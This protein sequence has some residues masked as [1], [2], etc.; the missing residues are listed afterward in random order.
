MARMAEQWSRVD[1]IVSCRN[2]LYF[3]ALVCV[4]AEKEN[5]GGFG[6]LDLSGL[7]GL[8]AACCRFRRDSLLSGGGVSEVR[9]KNSGCSVV[10]GLSGS[11]QAAY[12]K[13]AAGCRS[14]RWPAVRLILIGF[15][16][17][18][19]QRVCIEADFGERDRGEADGFKEAGRS[20]AVEVLAL[21][22]SG[23]F[24]EH[25]VGDAVEGI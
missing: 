20:L 15:T 2:I 3:E 8:R 16:P 11:Q 6:V 5:S 14:P 4:R 7:L 1:F 22:E 17:T 19:A 21:E 24:C 12:P 18:Y 9:K 10:L 25:D 23:I 13:A